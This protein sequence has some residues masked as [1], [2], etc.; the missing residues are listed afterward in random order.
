M[1]LSPACRGMTMRANR[2]E[3]IA[4]RTMRPVVYIPV[5]QELQA[6]AIRRYDHA[7]SV[8]RAKERIAR[9]TLCCLSLALC[10]ASFYSVG[11]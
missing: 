1:L 10:V 5:P 2:S 4:N 11:G 9:L 6:A 7:R 8:Q 3:W